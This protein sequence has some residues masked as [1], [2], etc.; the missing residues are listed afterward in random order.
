MQSTF[1][2]KA[3][4]NAVSTTK[5]EVVLFWSKTCIGKI[6]IFEVVPSIIVEVTCVP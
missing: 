2:L 3:Y 6:E 1:W 4:F 5:K